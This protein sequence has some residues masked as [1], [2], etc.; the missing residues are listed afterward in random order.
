[1]SAIT[2]IQGI[3][4][5]AADALREAGVSTVDALLER[6]AAPAGR[7]ELARRTGLDPAAILTWTNHADLFR[8]K[9]VAGHYA[10]LLEVAGVDSVP[11]LARRNATHLH[12]TLVEVNENRE[13]VHALPPES[14]VGA[15]INQARGLPRIVT[16]SDTPAGSGAAPTAVAEPVVRLVEP[17]E[18]PAGGAA[19][20]PRTLAIGAVLGLLGL[21]IVVRIFRGR[22]GP[23][24]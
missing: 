21:F 3:D 18:A 24:D 15:W 4:D 11:E 20:D 8:V 17:T 7:A 16:H 1:M 5:A 23:S 2:A 10:E 6:A 12:T 22:R 14:E 9:G 19:P 13:V